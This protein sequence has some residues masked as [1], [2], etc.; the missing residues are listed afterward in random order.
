MENKDDK[1]DRTSSSKTRSNITSD[2]ANTSFYYY[3]YI[4]IQVGDPISSLLLNDKYIIIGT[5]MGKIIL[6]CLNPEKQKIFHLSKDNNE[7]IS[8]LSFIEESNKLFASIG[9][10]KILSYN[11]NNTLYNNI[12][13]KTTDIYDNLREHD[14]YCENAYI[15]MSKESL[16]KI[17]LF[18][19]EF[20]ETI[21]NDVYFNYQIISFINEPK[22][23]GKIKSTN[24]Y[25]PLD[26]DGTF[27]C[28]V[29]YLNDKEDRN[30]CVQLL[31]QSEIIDN[32]KFKFKIDK[33]YG[34]ISHAKVFEGKII[35]VHDLNKCEIRKIEKQFELIDSFT[36]IGD[37]VY[38]IDILYNENTNFS[39][40]DLNHNNFNVN[41]GGI[42][43]KVKNNLYESYTNKENIIQMFDN[44][45]FEKHNYRGNKLP[46]IDYNRNK[47][48]KF[49]NSIELKSDTLKLFDNK[50]KEKKFKD[51]NQILTIITLDIDG[52]V[53]KY[54]NGI[55]EKIFNLYDIKE[56]DKDHKDKKFFNMGYV[57]FIKTDLNFFCITTDFGCYIIK[58]ND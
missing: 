51:F 55:E 26:Y 41:K 24:Y 22:K 42:E 57:Y 46:K 12:T 17:E 38:S 5:M 11:L 19:P 31:T 50:L 52:N 9:D 16:L 54:E 48:F 36:H 18:N 4:E 56:I 39:N 33:K 28:W 10:V 58:R 20:E 25:V 32:V 37:E 3:D 40:E 21:K 34:H 8:G 29:E 15:L 45:K 49:A 14:I 30:L 47:K 1:L 35:I 2:N 53:N 43:I 27:F 23:K 13:F 6:F 7:N 44:Q